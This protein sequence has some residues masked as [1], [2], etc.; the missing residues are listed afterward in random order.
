[1]LVLLV[2]SLALGAGAAPRSLPEAVAG[3]ALAEPPLPPRDAVLAAGTRAVDH[4]YTAGGGATADSGWRWAPYFM[5]VEALYDATGD[6]RY[7]SWLQAWGER[8]AW[9]PSS[10]VT[11]TSNPDTRAALQ[12][13]QDL[14]ADGLPVDLAPA[15]RTMSADL[16]LDPSTYW[17]I[18]SLFMGLPL[19]QRW[20][21]RTGDGAYVAKGDAFYAYLKTR[22]HTSWRTGCTDTGLFDASEDLWWRDCQYVAQRDALGNKVF[23][24]RGNGWV[25][26]ALAR[27]LMVTPPSDPRAAEYRD[28][29]RRMSTRLAQLQGPDGLWRTSLLS[30]SLHPA[31][32]TSGTALFAYAMAYGIRTGV[33]DRATFLPVVQRAWAGLTTTSLQSDGF[34]SHCQTVAEAPGEPSTTTSIGYCVGAFALA[35]SEVA[36]LAG[37]AAAPPAGPAAALA[38]DSFTRTVDGGLGTADT[39]GAWVIPEP[40]T[41]YAVA[42]GAARITTPAGHTRT[43]SLAGP[44]STSSRLDVTTWTTPTEVGSTYIA[45]VGRQVHGAEYGVRAVVSA[46]GAVHVQARRSGTTLQSTTLPDL[47]LAPGEPL[48]V[49]AE[50][51][52]TWPTTL[53][54]KVWELGTPEPG[55]WQVAVTDATPDLQAAGGAGLVSYF[56]QNGAPAAVVVS[57]DD[58]V[59]TA[60]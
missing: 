15:D 44:A 41:D 45:V 36:Q 27:T 48:R 6:P 24:S 4:W 2:L 37:P 19:W 12:V 31:P 28:M 30:P 53:R 42:G 49:R 18:D 3:A 46:A 11:P 43:A 34:L 47:R 8:H 14:A 26:G 52:G 7:R 50:V 60:G 10:A 39:G 13:W 55:D 5:G 21:D 38:A 35:A 51:T 23:W 20:T 22:G 16:A 59:A 1:V 29:L 9:T 33:L 56:S 17:W 58:L 57:F 54:G 25:L 40:A 32:E